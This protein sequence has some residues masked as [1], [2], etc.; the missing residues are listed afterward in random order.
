MTRPR[1][2]LL[3]LLAGFLLPACVVPSARAESYAE[4]RQAYTQLT[5]SSDRQ[6]LR[7]NWEGLLQRFDQFVGEHP[8]DAR[9]DKVFFLQART[10]DGLARA[11]GRAADARQA[12]ARYLAMTSRFPASNLADDALLNAG[13]ITESLL[14]DQAAA[15][16]YYRRLVRDLPYGDMVAEARQRLA[17]LD[18][19]DN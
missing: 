7:S 18:P 11:S 10:W 1:I 3:L 17:E 16:D 5:Q 14:H 13:R 8:L 15:V 2:F 9:L 4:L 6:R 19:A 12:E